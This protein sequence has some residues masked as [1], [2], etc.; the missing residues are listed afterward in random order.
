MSTTT[1][2]PLLTENR[3]TEMKIEL[4]KGVLLE[5]F[6]NPTNDWLKEFFE[7][8]PF[9]ET[10]IA[11]TPFSLNM[12]AERPQD[13]EAMNIRLVYGNLM[14]LSDSQ[15]SDERLWAA[16]CLGPF[17]SYVQYR[18]GVSSE[19]KI[20]DHFFF[21]FG[22]RR[23]VIRNAISRLWWIGRLSYEETLAD[24]FAYS[25]YLSKHADFIFHVFELNLSN[26]KQLVRTLME[27][28]LEFEDNNINVN[29][30]H[31]GALMKYFNVLGGT[32][33]LD[34]MPTEALQEKLRL[35]LHRIVKEE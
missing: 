8:D 28:L 11:Y 33:I 10:N 31:L 29:T 15:A 2:L 24:P 26:N 22:P 14:H 25:D 12:D 35:R 5:K 32:Y 16:L 17:Y 3:I 34:M 20:R 23:S 27:I 30:N 13:S 18:W 9:R 7:D 4:D 21:N 1:F 19:Q 6:Q